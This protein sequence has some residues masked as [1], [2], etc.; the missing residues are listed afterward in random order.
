MSD[1]KKILIFGAGAIGRGFLPHILLP[2]KC[3][4]SFVDKNPKLVEL[5]K[6]HSN[7]R[8]VIATD[9]GYEYNNID[10][11]AVYNYGDKIYIKDYDL[12]FTCV[13]PNQCYEL[14]DYLKDAKA[15][16]SCE[17]DNKSA[18][19]LRQLSGN[20]NIYFGI[21]DVITSNTASAEML[22]IDPLSIVTEKGVL[23]LEQGNYDLPSEV[24]QLELSELK[25]HWMCKMFIHNMPHAIVAYLGSL[26][27]YEFIHQA[28]TDAEINEVVCGALN[29]MT[30]AVI[31]SKLAD[32]KFARYYRDKELKRF[33]NKLLFDPIFRVARAPIRKLSSDNR[34]ILGLR[35]CTFYKIDPYNIACGIKAALNYHNEDDSEAK[36]IQNL[37]RDVSDAQVLKEISGIEIDDPLSRYIL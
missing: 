11:V 14:V 27:G 19:K 32:E 18:I 9:S 25:M 5:M 2:Y 1:K 37:R 4:L 16:I 15:V 3:E 7:Y 33:R 6:G 17:N 34:L 36:Y 23:V 20:K 35:I 31:I 29:E 10:Y 21:P 26:R 24:L 22:A 8:A 13:G 30:E 12:V 28:M